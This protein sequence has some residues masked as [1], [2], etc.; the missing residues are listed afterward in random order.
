M[1]RGVRPYQCSTP[2]EPR[3]RRIEID[4]DVAIS[5]GLSRYAVATFAIYYYEEMN[6]SLRRCCWKIVYI[7]RGKGRSGPL[8]RESMEGRSAL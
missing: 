2:D 5:A 3:D 4:G 7:E 1:I 6:N 8:D